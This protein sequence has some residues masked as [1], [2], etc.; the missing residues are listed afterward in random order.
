M[1]FSIKLMLFNKFPKA[2]RISDYCSPEGETRRTTLEVQFEV[3][4]GQTCHLF[5]FVCRLH[6][7]CF[8]N[9]LKKILL[10]NLQSCECI[11][12]EVVW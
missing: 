12:G 10:L 6:T 4:K 8:V 1:T 2:S 9:K 11:I 5:L 3:P 7:G